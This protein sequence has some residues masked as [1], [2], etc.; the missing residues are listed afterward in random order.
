MI[1]RRPFGTTGHLSSTTLFGAAALSRVTQDEADRTFD[2]LLKY[3]VNHIDVAASYGDAEL[4]V[5]PWMARHRADFF[6]ATK[7]GERT[8]AAA[9]EELYRS[10]DRLQTDSIDLI[11]LHNLGHPD[12][13]EQAMGPDGALAALTEAR[14]QGLVRFIGVTGHGLNIAAF[15]KRSLE[16]FAFDSVLLPYNYTMQLDQQYIADFEDLMTLCEARGVAV[17]TIKSITRGPWGPQDRWAATWYQPLLE[18]DDID[19][20]VHWVMGRPG[21]F[22]NTVGDI[23]V[24]PK[25]LDAAAR[26]E[27]RPSDAEMRAMVREEKMSN[28][29]A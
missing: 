4:R 13:W 14:E 1:E 15:H 3:G 29:F 23:S 19:R 24:L 20:A 17:Q 10:L 21:I 8:Y 28:L 26:F 2:L 22:L 6:L 7:T 27:R 16:R 12:E 11:Q 5:G 18:Q 25:V 9:R